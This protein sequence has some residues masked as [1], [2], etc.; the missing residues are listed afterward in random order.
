LIAAL[1]ALS[2][3]LATL[4]VNVRR[5][6][7]RYKIQRED[8]YR[9]SQRTAIVSV[10]VSAFTFRREYE[11]LANPDLWDRDYRRARSLTAADNVATTFLNEL[12]IAKFAL[13]DPVLHGALDDMYRG[14]ESVLTHV[15][16][17][18]EAFMTQAL[19]RRE[20]VESIR[21]GLRQFDATLG[22]LQTVALQRLKPIALG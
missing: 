22:I 3:V 21:E 15:D 9:N 16:R 6:E 1:I 12:T 19:E 10:C 18:E 20:A 17:A 11:A 8:E 5:D 7:A 2:G 4:I 14:W 13:E